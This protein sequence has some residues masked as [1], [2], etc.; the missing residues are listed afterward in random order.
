[1]TRLSC[2]SH[3]LQTFRAGLDSISVFELKLTT[4]NERVSGTHLGA[5]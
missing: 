2:A 5:K 3:S 1:V 4:G